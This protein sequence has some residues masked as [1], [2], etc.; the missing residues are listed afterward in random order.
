M[1]SNANKQDAAWRA[2]KTANS[3]GYIFTQFNYGD[4]DEQRIQQ[5]GASYILYGYEECPTTKR[6]HLQG[7]LFWTGKKRGSALIKQLPGCQL[8]V[9]MGGVKANYDYCSK[10]G[11]IYEAGTKPS[12]QQEKGESSK[13]MW[14][15]VLAYAQAGDEDSIMA[16]YPGLYV[17]HFNKWDAIFLRAAAKQ[18]PEV[19]DGEMTGVWIQGPP[20]AS[21]SAMARDMAT[22]KLYSKPGNNK[23]WFNYRY[24]KEVLIEDFDPTVKGMSY[25]MK[26]WTDRYKF[27][28]EIKN[29]GAEILPDR[30]IV[31]SNYTIEECF[32]PDDQLI[33]AMKRRFPTVINLTD[34]DGDEYRH[35]R[36]RPTPKKPLETKRP[37]APPYVFIYRKTWH[38]AEN[39]HGRNAPPSVD[40]PRREGQNAPPSSA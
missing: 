6:P 33:G 19:R 28:V 12:D 32:G 2:V 34:E 20:G 4:E 25:D 21:K 31:T 8:R 26:I 10:S 27:K 16:E 36:Q 23:W 39:V 40:F 37:K 35:K 15:S 1:S 38:F 9:A 24:E 11:K 3:R 14:A 29:G 7:Y 22:G 18:V 17:A 30:V 13:Q 5:C